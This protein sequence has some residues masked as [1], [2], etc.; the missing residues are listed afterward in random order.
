MESHKR[1]RVLPLKSHRAIWGYIFISP[2][3]IRLLIFTIG[4][5]LSSFYYSFC[6]YNILSSPRWIG[7]ANFEKLFFDD[8]LFWKSPIRGC[9]DIC[10][11][12]PGVI[13]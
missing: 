5:L 6:D 12:L 7:L 9:Q 13:L 4:P 8:P 1:D 10:V 2:W 11:N 3:L